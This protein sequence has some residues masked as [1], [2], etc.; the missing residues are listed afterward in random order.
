MEAPAEQSG[1]KYTILDM[2]PPQHGVIMPDVG[3]RQLS[4]LRPALAV[5]GRIEVPLPIQMSGYA[6][7]MNEEAESLCKNFQHPVSYLGLNRVGRD[8]PQKM[9]RDSG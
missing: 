8:S 5:I 1:V 6:R 3:P 7:I 4:D 2:P 9:L